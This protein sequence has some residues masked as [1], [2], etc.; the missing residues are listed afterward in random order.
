MKLNRILQLSIIFLLVFVIIFSIVSIGAYLV[1]RDFKN[2]NFTVSLGPQT[3]S[4]TYSVYNTK[5]DEIMSEVPIKLI[6]GNGEVVALSISD[7]NGTGIFEDVNTGTYTISSDIGQI[8]IDD[9]EANIVLKKENQPVNLGLTTP[10]NTLVKGLLFYQAIPDPLSI[11][12][13]QFIQDAASANIDVLNLPDNAYDVSEAQDGSVMAY[14]EGTK[15]YVVSVYGGPIY[16]NPNADRMFQSMYALKTI[17]INDLDCSN[18]VTAYNWFY[19]CVKLTTVTLPANMTIIDDNAFAKCTELVTINIPATVEKIGN[20]AF[21][22]CKKLANLTF[23]EGSQLKTIGD[24]AFL[25]CRALTTVDLSQSIVSIG[26]EAFNACSVLQNVYLADNLT[27]IGD[28]AFKSTALT[29]IIIPNGVSE[30][31]KETFYGCTK[32]TLIVLP[33]TITDIGYS[34]FYN[35]YGLRNLNF[36]GTEEQWNAIPKGDNWNYNANNFVVNYNYVP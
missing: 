20:D 6:N 16:A 34:A 28:T 22:G 2:D 4:L 25:N 27:Y 13:I 7:E 35:C 17:N 5:T 8:T 1:D 3:T 23:E 10:S 19:S 21:S 15:L 29:S 18:I 32:L 11:T 26:K 14:V 36:T 24:L 12:E 30:I 9:E 31:K 33:D